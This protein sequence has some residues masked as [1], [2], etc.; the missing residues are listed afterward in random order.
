MKVEMTKRIDVSIKLPIEYLTD[1]ELRYALSVRLEEMV[2]RRQ[3][4]YHNDLLGIDYTI[5]EAYIKENPRKE[6]LIL[7]CVVEIVKVYKEY[8]QEE[9]DNL[10]VYSTLKLVE[11]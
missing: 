9:L 5:H 11:P 4:V 2:R 8:T 6:C 3:T 10:G 7:K 1:K